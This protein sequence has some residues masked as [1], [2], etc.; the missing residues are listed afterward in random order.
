LTSNVEALSDTAEQS[1]VPQ[2]NFSNLHPANPSF[3]ELKLPVRKP[4]ASLQCKLS[5]DNKN[6]VWSG[7]EA[8]Q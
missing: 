1:H 5:Q 2:I 6:A 8:W 3:K 4:T 7:E